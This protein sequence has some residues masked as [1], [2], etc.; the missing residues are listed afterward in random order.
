VVCCG[1]RPVFVDIEETSFALSPD[2]LDD[3]L[4]RRERVK[5]IVPV[6]PFGEMAAMD[7]IV[8]IAS[9]RGIPIIED[10][11]CA[12]GASFDGQLAGR[13][14][15]MGCYSFHPRKAITTAEGGAVVT[16]D[17]ALATR[18]RM[19]RNHGQDPASLPSDFVMAGLNQRLTELQAALGRTQL[20]K[21]STMIASRRSQAAAYQELFAGSSIQAP[22]TRAA[23]THVYQSY[24]VLIPEHR[25][26]QRND[27]IRVLRESGIEA[28][29]GTHHIPLLRFYRET[30]GYAPGDFP[31]A[32]L[33]AGRAIALP[34]HPYLSAQ[35]Q[36]KVA[37]VLMAVTQ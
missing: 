24:V 8:A 5:A 16:D 23:S 3:S 18:L 7:R 34:L 21:L 26:P 12:L 4:K 32:D 9:D 31:V 14:G 15:L 36:V 13:I 30:F 10:A 29:I 6:H 20:R 17:A 2:A 28:S 25:A 33:V 1:A 37:E 27:I 35:E 19:L 11:A 22:V